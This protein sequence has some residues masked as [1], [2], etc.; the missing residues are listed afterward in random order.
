MPRPGQV[1]PVVREP[2]LFSSVRTFARA[3]LGTLHTR[4]DLVTTEL[5]DGA[6]RV[7]YL[8]ASGLVGILAL[9]G[10]FFFAMLWILAAFWDTAYRFWVIGGIFLIYFALGAGLLTYAWKLV[11]GRPR[12]LGQTL[13][14]L[15]RDVDHLQRAVK[16]K[17]QQP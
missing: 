8:V 14:E 12:F 13:D 11:A 3:L 6:V 16:S 4:L 5:E 9:H 1:D 7:A 2:G 15:K 17:E 10:A